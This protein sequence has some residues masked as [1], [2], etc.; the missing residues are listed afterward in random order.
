MNFV[1]EF[2]SLSRSRLGWFKYEEDRED[3][4]AEVAARLVVYGGGWL[5]RWDKKRSS[6]SYYIK[7]S[8]QYLVGHVIREEYGEWSREIRAY[9]RGCE[10]D[11]GYNFEEMFSNLDAGELGPEDIVV[12]GSL[13]RDLRERMKRDWRSWERSW[14]YLDLLL[15]GWN[16]KEIAEKWGIAEGTAEKHKQRI[17]I[18]ID[19]LADDYA[20]SGDKS[21][22]ER[23]KE[24]KKKTVGRRGNKGR[25]LIEVM[26]RLCGGV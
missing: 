19:R 1:P 2:I 16:N 17:K 6:L 21:L 3:L 15:E 5:S 4:F 14:E 8:I 26:Y 9:G 12:G 11:E 22:L 23:L 18:S 10:D 7:L 13:G 25:L 24:F 20:A